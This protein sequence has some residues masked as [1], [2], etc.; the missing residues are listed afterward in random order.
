M[1]DFIIDKWLQFASLA[2]GIIAPIVFWAIR[3]AWKRPKRAKK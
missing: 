3:R 2:M 1:T